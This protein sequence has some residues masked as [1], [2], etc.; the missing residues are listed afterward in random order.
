VQ[1]PSTGG[2]PGGGPCGRQAP[3]PRLGKR[4]S[5]QERPHQAVV[6]RRAPRSGRWHHVRH[7]RLL[8]IVRRPALGR[9]RNRVEGPPSGTQPVPSYS[10]MRPVYELIYEDAPSIPAAP[11]MKG[12][13]RT[14]GTSDKVVAW[15]VA[16]IRSRSSVQCAWRGHGSASPHP[17]S[18]STHSWDG[19]HNLV[20]TNGVRRSC[21]RHP[22]A[23]PPLRGEQARLV[24]LLKN[25]RQKRETNLQI[26]AD[27]LDGDVLLS[28][29][30]GRT[31]R[32]VPLGVVPKRPEIQHGAEPV[33]ATLGQEHRRNPAGGYRAIV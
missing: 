20:E 14:S 6:R 28:G 33:L 24:E 16:F 22:A 32:R 1:P 9:P 25:L 18:P 31:A 27:G 21:E 11:S 5:S 19:H 29:I 15:K 23:R 7:G 8:G 4:P 26:L 2:M 12:V 13:R 10:Y 3:S 17:G 30:A